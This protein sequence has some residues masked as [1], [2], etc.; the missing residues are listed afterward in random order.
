MRCSVSKIRTFFGAQLAVVSPILLVLV[1]WAV[2]QCLRRGWGQHGHT[3]TGTDEHGPRELKLLRGERDAAL[4]ALSF[5]A[6][7]G[8]YALVSLTNRPEANW[9]VCAYLAGVPALAWVWRK[10]PRRTVWRRVMTAGV[11]LGVLM[12]AASRSTDLLYT[13]TSLVTPDVTDRLQLGPFEIDP[14]ADP[15]NALRGGRELGAA[16]SKHRDEDSEDAPFIFSDRY[17]LTAWAAFYTEGRPHTYCMN[18]GDRRYNQ[19][20]LRGGWEDL[21]SKDGLFVTGGDPLKT[22]A[23]IAYMVAEG[24]FESGELI[25]TVTVRRGKTIIKTFNIAMMRGYSGKPWTVRAEKY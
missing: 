16:L 20:D 15:T 8:G 18:I 10:Q 2:G 25:D 5:L 21:I 3:R 4:L 12:G 13:A 1:L 22:Q 6:V 23:F 11:A 24:A 14:D 9:A 7:F 19:Y 17:Q